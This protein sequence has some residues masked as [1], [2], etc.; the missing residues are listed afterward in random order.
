M[1][2]AR[3][4]RRRVASIVALA[5]LFMQLAV[6]AYA[7]PGNAAPDPSMA[8]MPCQQMMAGRLAVDQDQP[9]L[10]FQH[11]QAD[12]AQ[13]QPDLTQPAVSLAAALVS[14]C[15]LAAATNAAHDAPAWHAHERERGRAPPPPHSIAHCCWRV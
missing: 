8:G 14:W 11:C 12:A 13:P 15:A 3:S 9:A 10:C 5:L 1:P 6:A 7:C 2:L 4:L